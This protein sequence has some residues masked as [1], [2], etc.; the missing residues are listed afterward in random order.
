MIPKNNNNFLPWLE[1]FKV[2]MRV[3]IV[4]EAGPIDNP[5]LKSPFYVE[6]EMNGKRY[7]M[8]L[9]WTSYGYISRDFGS[10]TKDW[11]NTEIVYKGKEKT[12]HGSMANVWMPYLPEIDV[13]TP[14]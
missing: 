8:S 13:G 6:V 4:S 12:K 14:F 5:K 10:D 9:N 7:M 2:G 3:K 1:E 11:V